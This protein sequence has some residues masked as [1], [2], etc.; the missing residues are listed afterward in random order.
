MSHRKEQIGS[1]LK[2]AIVNVLQRQLQDPRVKGL[3]SITKVDV[4]PDQRRAHIYVSVMP[5]RF[6]SRTV[7]GLNAAV[8]FIQSKVAK[9]VSLR[10]MPDLEF[11]LDSSLKKEAQVFDAIRN[12]VSEDKLV[13]QRRGDAQVVPDDTVSSGGQDGSEE[14]QT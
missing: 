4:T 9:A 13:A 10:S 11:H 1:S 2:R 3:V 14:D 8:G 5:E 7:R 12:A 6:E